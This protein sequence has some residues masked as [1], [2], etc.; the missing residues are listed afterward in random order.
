MLLLFRSIR[1]CP[2]FP[3]STSELGRSKVSPRQ[4]ITYLV[5]AVS[6]LPLSF[7]ILFSVFVSFKRPSL[8]FGFVPRHFHFV[9]P[10]CFA[11]ILLM[12]L[13]CS[14]LDSWP[15]KKH[16]QIKSKITHYD[17]SSKWYKKIY[18]FSCFFLLLYPLLNS[19]ESLLCAFMYCFRNS[20][21]SSIFRNPCFKHKWFR[22]PFSVIVM[23]VRSTIPKGQTHFYAK[24][25]IYTSRFTY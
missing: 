13:L 12:L 24:V 8:S 23:H 21:A 19:D 1:F 14:C 2:E 5:I 17:N 9:V 25:Q 4:K 7:G 15:Y 6:N 3:E 16:Q 11:V 22:S 10:A 20:R 18:H